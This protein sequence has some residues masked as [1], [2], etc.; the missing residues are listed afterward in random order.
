M[1][2]SA[3]LKD[4][5]FYQVRRIWATGPKGLTP[6]V[7]ALI[8][9]QIHMEIYQRIALIVIAILYVGLFVLE[10]VKEEAD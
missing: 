8:V 6:D 7:I 2:S 9:L 5:L 4:V 3:P 10:M 1:A